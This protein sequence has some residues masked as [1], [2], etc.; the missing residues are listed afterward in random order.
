MIVIAIVVVTVYSASQ[1]K[2]ALAEAL[3]N[4]TDF[5]VSQSYLDD[6][7]N[8]AIAVLFYAVMPWRRPGQALASPVKR[9]HNPGQQRR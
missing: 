5:T 4:L 2:K 8:M 3:N 9:F 1:R 7:G 6:I